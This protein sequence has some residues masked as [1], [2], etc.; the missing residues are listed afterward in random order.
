MSTPRPW[1]LV[2]SHI[3]FKHKWYTLR[4]DEVELPNGHMVDDFFVSE[5]PD[6]AYVFP[7][8]EQQEV[9]FVRQYKHAARKV[10]L[11]LPAGSFFPDQ[12]QAQDA[13]TRELLEETGAVLTQPLI[14][15]GVLHDNP[16]KDTN[17][18]HLFLA[19]NVRIEQAQL[20]DVTE[21]IEVVR[22]PIDQVLPKIM[23][24]E[25]CVSGSVAI[26]FLALKHLQALK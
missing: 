7:V 24:G 5:R 19:Q 6:G 16:A 2:R 18:L 11:E 15:L 12:E 22:V 21:D 14:P 10:F 17:R 20:L 23:D 13:A 4:R 8:T 26:S 3:A 9:L 1:R 25:I